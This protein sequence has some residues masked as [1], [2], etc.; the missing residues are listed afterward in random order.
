MQL[1]EKHGPKKWTL[2]ARHLKGRI[3]KQCRER[4]HNHLNPNIKK[5]AW[6]EQEDNVIYQAHKQWGNQWAK[7]AK[8]LPG[9]TD[10]AIKNHWNSTMR[11][12]YDSEGRISEESRR[13]RARGKP[14]KTQN[15]QN[16][17]AVPVRNYQQAILPRVESSEI[18]TP[19][20]Q[21]NNATHIAMY[22][23]DWS[24][25]FYDQMSSQSSGGAF[26]VT[27]AT[28]S[29][30]PLTP[31]PTSSLLQNYEQDLQIESPGTIAENTVDVINSPFRLFD[32]NM[33]MQPT[34]T[35][36]VHINDE[37]NAE[38]NFLDYYPSPGVSPLKGVSI[39][40]QFKTGR[41]VPSESQ[42]QILQIVDMPPT[43][44]TTPPILRRGSKSR[45]RRDSVNTSSE[46]N[47]TT[48][49]QI[50]LDNVSYLYNK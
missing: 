44:P 8:L 50:T 6:T 12:K 45:R 24:T 40:K 32:I 41:I 28:P 17:N 35:K 19:I 5:T 42:G 20:Y 29:P 2:I 3:G 1:V 4:W 39:G 27:E 30:S 46:Y 21:E 9:R 11:R 47:S 49:V 22:N 16:E 14:I 31:T 37:G 7:I 36:L 18:I 33:T 10:N 48:E 43:R 38:L 26:S 25:E 34:P 13:G 23:E 15:V